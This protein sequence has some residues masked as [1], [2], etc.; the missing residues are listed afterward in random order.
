MITKSLLRSLSLRTGPPGYQYIK[1]RQGTG[2]PG[3]DEIVELLKDIRTSRFNEETIRIVAD[4]KQDI[5]FSLQEKQLSDG[6]FKNI[7]YLKIASGNY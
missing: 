5:G 1:C 7:N 2:F 6:R 3:P 4:L